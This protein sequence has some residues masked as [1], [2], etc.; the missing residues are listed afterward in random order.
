MLVVVS[1]VAFISVIPVEKA[2]DILYVYIMHL[3]LI[4]KVR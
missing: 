2:T 1:I 4:I 3:K